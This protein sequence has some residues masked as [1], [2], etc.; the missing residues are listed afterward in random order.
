MRAQILRGLFFGCLSVGVVVLIPSLA[1]LPDGIFD[2]AVACIPIVIGYCGI[3]W[4]SIKYSGVIKANAK[5]SGVLHFCGLLLVILGGFLLLRGLLG[6][7]GSAWLLA[8]DGIG[9][10]GWIILARLFVIGVIPGLLLASVG[11]WLRRA[12]RVEN[13]SGELNIKMPNVES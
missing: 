3:R 9:Q 11:F 1:G 4:V 2:V 8:L 5:P 10:Q 12:N 13:T 7:I 6:L